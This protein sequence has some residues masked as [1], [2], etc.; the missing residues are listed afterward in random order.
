MIVFITFAV[1]NGFLI[2]ERLLYHTIWTDAYDLLVQG[3]LTSGK[4]M[5][6]QMFMAGKMSVLVFCVVA[7][8]RLVGRYNV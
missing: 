6:F 5:S 7:P 8:C 2:W 3:I 1:L 4:N